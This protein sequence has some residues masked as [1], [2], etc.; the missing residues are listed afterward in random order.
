MGSFDA[1]RG[2]SRKRAGSPQG[3]GACPACAFD[4][5]RLRLK[6]QDAATQGRAASSARGSEA[7]VP[8][9]VGKP[10]AHSP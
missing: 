1:L 8:T 10:N 2:S 4:A 7:A 3:R 6:H 5:T 9:L